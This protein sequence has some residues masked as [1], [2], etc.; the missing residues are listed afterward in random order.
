MFDLIKEKCYYT[1]NVQTPGIEYA[2]TV[3]FGTHKEEIGFLSVEGRIRQKSISIWYN[4][5]LIHP[6]I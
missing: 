6:E 4:N 1:A 2:S 5:E 3:W